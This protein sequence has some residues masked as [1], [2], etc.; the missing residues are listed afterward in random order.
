[1]VVKMRDKAAAKGLG[2]KMMWSSK[3]RNR[4]AGVRKME[5]LR[6]H[7]A[8]E[9]YEAR[10]WARALAEAQVGWNQP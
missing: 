1:M 2:L 3:Q 7:E 6:A 5:E 10:D 9:A 8:H 4:R